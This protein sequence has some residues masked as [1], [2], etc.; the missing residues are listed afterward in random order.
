MR[1]LQL[2]PLA[3]SQLK[4]GRKLLQ[5]LDF[6]E[7]IWFDEGEIVEL[8]NPNN[9]F[10]AKAYLAEQNKGIGW[11]FST[12]KDTELDG[13]FFID[14]LKN[15]RAS[16]SALFADDSTT[17]FRIFNGEG[18]GLGG[19]TLDWYDGYILLQRYSVGI[20]QNR[21]LILAAINKVYPECKGIIAKNRFE[22]TSLPNSEVLAGQTPPDKM[23][24][25]EN[26]VEYIVSLNEG[27]MTGIFLDQREV[28]EY[29][30]EELAAG[31]HVLNTFSYT[32]AFSVAAALGGAETTSVD[33]ANRSRELTLEQFAANQ[34]DISDHQSNPDAAHHVYVMDV[35]DFFNYAERNDKNFDVVVLDPPSFA[36]TKK[37]TFKATTDYS[38]LVAQSI[39]VLNDGGFIICSTNAAN[40]EAE[41]FE[42]AILT[43][44]ELEDADLSLVKSFKLPNDFPTPSASPESD[45]LKVFVYSVDKF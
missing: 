15:A 40:F 23:H 14:I 13:Q 3:T 2:K 31:K 30:R 17:A 35:F 9:K 29:L 25:L 39:R 21:Q 44:G 41:A 45:Y 33:A 27:W 32:G 7:E 12:E 11:V 28:R 16:R 36:R 34:I 26:G 42:E 1:K 24:V 37:R 18:D 43:G 5:P 19:F 38:D 10:L 4:E 22:S 6:K 8:Y 20:Y